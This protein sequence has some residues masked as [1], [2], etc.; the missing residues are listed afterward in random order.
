MN[1][2]TA[3]ALAL[4]FLSGPA[5]A[6]DPLVEAMPLDP[7]APITLGIGKPN[8][9]KLARRAQAE[10]EPYLSK[11]MKRPV[12]VE[13]LPDYDALSAA[14][15]D[16]KVDI[17]W[18]TPLAFVHAAQRRA[19]VIAIAKA[20]R[21]GK[22]FYR[23]AF[24]VRPDS[25]ARSLGDLAGKK[26]AYVSKSSS[27]GYL[28]PRAL[29]SSQGKDPDR[30]FREAIF[31]GDHPGVCQAVR[32]GKA[33][34]GATFSDEPAKGKQPQ[35]DGCADS[36]PMSDFR[37]V[38]ASGPITN[39]VIAA[40]PDFDER[41]VTPVLGALGGMA[42]TDEG[43]RILKGVFHAD[44]WGVAVDGDFKAIYEVMGVKSAPKVPVLPAVEEPVP[45]PPK[46]KAKAKKKTR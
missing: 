13:I 41:L 26:V 4:A 3:A 43:R 45:P 39:D 42:R 44:A 9:E 15:A 22:L 6:G 12:K 16:G 30:F 1:P 17:A 21:A 35:V 25:T 27:S 40:R 28:F 23:A 33:E 20:M 38:A 31:M 18:I 32:T 24:V 5:L 10:L 34:V 14:L 37:I 19:D 2:R 7:N 29:L 46:P 36:P 11:V 8:G